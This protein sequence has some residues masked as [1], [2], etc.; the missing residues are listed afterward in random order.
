MR[1]IY[2]YFDD[3]MFEIDTKINKS[4]RYLIILASYITM[5][6]IYYSGMILNKKIKTHFLRKFNKKP[7]DLKFVDNNN[8]I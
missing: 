1:L 5:V 7:N 2:L 6:I 8:Q 3:Y 4:V